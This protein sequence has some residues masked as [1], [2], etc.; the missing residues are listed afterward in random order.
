MCESS[1]QCSCHACVTKCMCD[2][3][4]AYLVVTKLKSKGRAR[5]QIA[6]QMR[7]WYSARREVSPP[8][9]AQKRGVVL[10]VMK[11]WFFGHQGWRTGCLSAFQPSHVHV[12]QRTE[13]PGGAHRLHA[14]ENKRTFCS[15]P[16]HL[17]CRV[18]WVNSVSRCQNEGRTFSFSC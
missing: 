1:C 5:T 10:F 16:R 8:F 14:P 4:H 17:L 6:K 2:A 12:V 18:L 15:V 9:A 13:T 3:L 7:I 11:V